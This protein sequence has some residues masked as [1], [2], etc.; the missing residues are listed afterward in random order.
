M[1]LPM[2]V[3]LVARHCVA[4]VPAGS[5]AGGWTNEHER[6]RDAAQSALTRSDVYS[7]HVWPV[8]R[9][10]F[11]PVAGALTGVLVRKRPS[12]ALAVQPYPLHPPAVRHSLPASLTAAALPV[13]PSGCPPIQEH[14][15]QEFAQAAAAGAIRSATGSGAD[16]RPSAPRQ[17]PSA[18]GSLESHI[19]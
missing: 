15:A 19:E 16:Y 9:A 3:G 17:V 7:K 8:R 11:L 13:A 1:H 4:R 14:A 5:R 12:S 18:T 10:A 2:F 6:T